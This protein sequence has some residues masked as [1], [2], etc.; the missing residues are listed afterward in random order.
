MQ[1]EHVRVIGQ[2]LVLATDADVDELSDRLWVTFPAGY[3]EYVTQLG[4][5][6]LGGS[7]VRI[8]PPWRIDNALDEWRH[9]IDKYWCWDEGLDVLPKAR[10]LECLVIGDTVEGDELVFHPNR[11]D[12]LFVLPR[13]SE[14]I[15]RAGSDLMAAIEWMCSSGELVEPFAEREF[16][17]F[18]SRLEPDSAPEEQP[19]IDPDGE[20][21][22]ELIDLVKRWAKRHGAMDKAVEVLRREARKAGDV[23]LLYEG[24]LINVASP[25]FAGY[26]AAWRV[27]GKDSRKQ[28]ATFRWGMGEGVQGGA[29][30]PVKSD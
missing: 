12:Q 5:G 21:L 18:D 22:D 30:E 2:P 29:Y 8:Y 11:L 20:S 24:L 10:A 25:L 9:R 26:G 4:E 6:V 15:H 7:Y 1:I 3:R 16:E 13:Y 14:Q 23:E 28:I 27:L 17:P 19:T